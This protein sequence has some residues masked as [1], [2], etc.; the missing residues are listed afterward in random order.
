MVHC[1]LV[2]CSCNALVKAGTSFVAQFCHSISD[3]HLI[4]YKL[5]VC[6]CSNVLVKGNQSCGIILSLLQ[7]CSLDL[8]KDGCM[9]MF[10]RP[11]EGNELVVQFCHSLATFIWF[12][13]SWLYEYNFNGLGKVNEVCDTVMSLKHDIKHLVPFLREMIR[14]VRGLTHYHINGSQMA[15]L[16]KSIPLLL[17]PWN[18]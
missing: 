12:S 16:K 5:V 3:V 1:K 13:T 2:V 17:L 14:F 10:Q 9:L 8:T 18:L 6:V 11:C 15:K 7:C 4:K